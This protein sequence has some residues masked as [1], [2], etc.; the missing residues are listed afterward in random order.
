MQPNGSDRDDGNTVAPAAQEREGTAPSTP[1]RNGW[2]PRTL[3]EMQRV[4]LLHL[5]RALQRARGPR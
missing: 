5:E 4:E 1:K 3:R 2:G